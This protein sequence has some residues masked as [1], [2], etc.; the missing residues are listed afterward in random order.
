MNKLPQAQCISSI[1]KKTFD[2]YQ[3]LVN[4]RL[5]P[6][7]SAQSAQS[8][9]EIAVEII[10]TAKSLASL[11]LPSEENRDRREKHRKALLVRKRKAWADMLK[12]L[13]HAGLASNLKP[14]IL[15]QNADQQW[16]RQQPT[17]PTNQRTDIEFLRGDSYFVK[18][19]GCLPSLRSLLPTHHTDLTTRELQRGYMFLESGFAMGIDLRAR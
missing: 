3:A 16:I 9:D 19:C 15:R 13:K 2:K 18:L 10:T 1:C 5:R 12:E 17:L 11:T 7:I 4:K 14:E 6:F 8:V